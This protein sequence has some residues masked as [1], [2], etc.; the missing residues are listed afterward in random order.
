MEFTV[1]ELRVIMRALSKFARTA[2]QE[3]D[4]QI[5]DD[6]F[7]RIDSHRDHMIME[8]DNGR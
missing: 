7:F 3:R 4:S 5:A 8:Q 6:L 1:D 2:V